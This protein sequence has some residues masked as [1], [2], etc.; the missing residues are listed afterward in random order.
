MAEDFLD[1]QCSRCLHKLAEECAE[2]F[3]AD[4]LTFAARSEHG[5]QS[6]PVIAIETL[7]AGD[8]EDAGAG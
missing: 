1:A 7:R 2:R 3:A 8:V 6:A 4:W 5:Q